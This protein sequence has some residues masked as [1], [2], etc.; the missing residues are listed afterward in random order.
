MPW[1]E[2]CAVDERLKFIADWQRGGLTVTELSRVHGVSRKTA[3]KWLARYTVSGPVGLLEQSRAPHTRP[4]AVVDDVVELV[5]GVRKRHPTWGARKILAALERERLG[6]RLPVASTVSEI[7]DRRGLVRHR[8]RRY[9]APPYGGPFVD[10][11][12]PNDVWSADFKGTLLL[13]NKHAC[14][15]FTLSDNASRYLLRCEGLSRTGA[16][17]V[18]PILESAFTEFGLPLAIRTDNGPPFATIAVGGL[19]RLAIWLVKL[20]IRPERIEPGKPTQNGR[21]ERL[22]KTLQEETARPTADTM[23]GQQRKFDEFR[24]VY[25]EDRPHEALGQHP[26]ASVYRPSLRPYPARLR[27]PEYGPEEQT[28]RI[29]YHGCMKWRGTEVFVSESLR[30]EP[31]GIKQTADDRWS[32]LY[33]PLVLG[34]L[35]PDNKLHRL[36]SPWRGR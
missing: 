21:H 29:R 32:V 33:G 36:R 18:Q 31:V 24:R 11:Q 6:V 25:N 2:S 7:L 23:S 30:G 22:H 27:E 4:W 20:G 26:P 9:R 19:S 5:V 17:E 12:R 34:Q 1:K 14:H 13:G 10:C 16:S 8:R 15:P 3:Y 35:G 28:R